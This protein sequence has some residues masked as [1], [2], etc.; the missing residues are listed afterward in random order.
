MIS[1]KKRG[2]N[3]VTSIVN[4]R[5]TVDVTTT[6]RYTNEI[7]SPESG[8]LCCLMQQV[9]DAVE[10]GHSGVKIRPQIAHDDHHDEPQVRQPHQY[11]GHD[12]AFGGY[13]DG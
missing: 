10:N 9:V 2:T 3:N 6:Y 11:A 1:R 12:G 4:I 13:L 7:I 8:R 5:L